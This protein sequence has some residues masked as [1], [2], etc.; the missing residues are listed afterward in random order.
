MIPR[1]PVR[2]DSRKDFL[3]LQGAG[4]LGFAANLRYYLQHKNP[5]SGSSERDR[6]PVTLP[7]WRGFYMGNRLR[8]S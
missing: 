3:N 8:Y 2:K 1:L 6:I 5:F 7:A 4:N